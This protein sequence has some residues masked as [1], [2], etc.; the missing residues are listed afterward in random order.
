MKDLIEVRRETKIRRDYALAFCG[1]D[2]DEAERWLGSDNDEYHGFDEDEMDSS[3][4]EDIEKEMY[5]AGFGHFVNSY[6]AQQNDD[7][8]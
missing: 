2:Q 8:F 7:W 4:P 1:G 3:G 6:A 5:L